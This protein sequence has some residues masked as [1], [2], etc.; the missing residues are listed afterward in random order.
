VD[1]SQIFSHS[2]GAESEGDRQPALEKGSPVLALPRP[3]LD[4]IEALMLQHP[5]V[6]C[7]VAHYFG[8]GVYMREVRAPGG[9]YVMSHAHKEAGLNILI[10]GR[11]AI[12]VNDK[13]IEIDG[14]YIFT[15]QP[16]RKFVR[17]ITDTIFVNVIATDETDIETI[18]ATYIN[19]SE[20]WL[21]AQQAAL[22]VRAGYNEL[23]VLSS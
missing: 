18:E 15:S 10:K 2:G 20:A 6:E 13:A 7:P 19:K 5:Q 8:P 14:P 9:T 12:I 4:A 21:D 1:I 17:V 23:G 16:G 3:T 11:I 22:D